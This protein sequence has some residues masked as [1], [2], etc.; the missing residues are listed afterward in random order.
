MLGPLEIILIIVVLGGLLLLHTATRVGSLALYLTIGILLLMLIV[1]VR[2][3]RSLVGMVI[4]LAFI[5]AILFWKLARS[6]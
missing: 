4:V 5:C 3:I 1:A 6:T 2:V